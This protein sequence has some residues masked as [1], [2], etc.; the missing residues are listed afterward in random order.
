MSDGSREGFVR[1]TVALKDR[2]FSAR[3]QRG[4][5]DICQEVEQ[6]SSGGLGEGEGRGFKRAEFKSAHGNFFKT[7]FRMS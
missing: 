4:V 3:C 5:D 1:R 6:I 7:S 2:W